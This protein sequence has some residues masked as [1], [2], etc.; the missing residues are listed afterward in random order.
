MKGK[1]FFVFSLCALMSRPMSGQVASS[2]TLV[3][4]VTDNSG[5]VVAGADVIAVQN[6]TKVSYHGKTTA[7][8][9]YSLPYVDVGTY[10]ITVQAVDFDKVVH[11]NVLVEVNATVR[12]DFSLKLGS[13]SNEVTV[14]DSPPPLATDDAA[15]IQ[16]LSTDAI[17]NLPI[18]GHDSLK[19][20]LT[21]AGVIQSGDVTVGD[22]PGES[23]AGP[24]T[25]GEQ[26]DVTL[27]GVT[28]MNTL[29]TTIDFP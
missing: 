29:H 22:P 14:T 3:G 28:I 26:N 8:G 19:L 21:T 23:F 20:A 13:V 5:A 18:A 9:D 16:T 24:G 25:R 6:A 12:T 4:T 11:S 2:T 7:S 15:L 27:D 1:L 10:T 17:N